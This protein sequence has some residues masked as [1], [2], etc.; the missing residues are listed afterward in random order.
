MCLISVHLTSCVAE[1]AYNTVI[2]NYL[3]QSLQHAEVWNNT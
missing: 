2:A 3:W 1:L